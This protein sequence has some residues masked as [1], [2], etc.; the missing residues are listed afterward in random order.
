M[1]GSFP[2][3]LINEILLRSK[4]VTLI[5]LSSLKKFFFQKSEG[6]LEKFSPT[7]T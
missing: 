4:G 3:W 5:R 2:E 6:Y 7:V 1:N